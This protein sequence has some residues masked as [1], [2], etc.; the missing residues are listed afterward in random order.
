MHV[1]SGFFDAVWRVKPGERYVFADAK[2]DTTP[3]PNSNNKTAVAS[4]A[5]FA[6]NGRIK[7]G[8]TKVATDSAIVSQLGE[9]GL[10]ATSGAAIALQPGESDIAATSSA[11][12]FWTPEAF[13]LAEMDGMVT[14][15]P[16]VDRVSLFHNFVQLDSSN[17]FRNP[18]LR[19]FLPD[20]LGNEVLNSVLDGIEPQ[21]DTDLGTV[22]ISAGST[23]DFTLTGADILFSPGT[24][25]R[26]TK[27]DREVIN[28]YL[29][30]T[31]VSFSAPTPAQSGYATSLSLL[32]LVDG[33]QNFAPGTLF[34]MDGGFGS[35]DPLVDGQSSLDTSDLVGLVVESNGSLLDAI[36][37]S[38]ETPG[39]FMNTLAA[40]LADGDN[41][42]L[43]LIFNQVDQ[44]MRTSEAVNFILI[45]DMDFN[46]QVDFDDIDAFVLG[47]NR[48]DLF[49]SVFGAPPLPNGDSDGN[50]RLDF[51]D[52]PGFVSLLTFSGQPAPE[53]SSVLLAVFSSAILFL[54]VRTGLQG[55]NEQVESG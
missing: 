1:T 18:Y 27:S 41:F 29:L 35:P 37:L 6:Q 45:G 44:A 31:A 47:L 25:V 43:D 2:K 8:F 55:Q 28:E 39:S 49:E 7:K 26:D 11:A 24:V 5:T 51:D 14:V 40:G 4:V 42:E 20:S 22:P 32:N 30:S 16:P 15:T 46:G 54:K 38:L 19:G 53:P 21:V 12:L 3:A 50:G 13:G 34:A 33:S 10:K 23:V 48:P 9:S 36:N 52:I 17:N